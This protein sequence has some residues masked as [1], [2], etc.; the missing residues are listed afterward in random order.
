MWPALSMHYGLSSRTLIIEN[1][2]PTSEV[3][4]P[5]EGGGP[6]QTIK[7]A[8]ELSEVAG[9]GQT[10]RMAGSGRVNRISARGKVC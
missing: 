1:V 3:T 10:K 6:E 7:A 5:V 4:P 8:G 2:T 9:S